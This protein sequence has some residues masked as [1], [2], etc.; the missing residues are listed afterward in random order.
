MFYLLSQNPTRVK[1]VTGEHRAVFIHQYHYALERHNQLLALR[2]FARP[3]IAL[4]CRLHFIGQVNTVAVNIV[5]LSTLYESA[6]TLGLSWI[7]VIRT[8][9]D[10]NV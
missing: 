5:L 1:A 3:S 9:V 7:Q 10:V 8:F 2:A 6:D 4:R